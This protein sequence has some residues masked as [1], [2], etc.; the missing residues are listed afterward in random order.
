[1]FVSRSVSPSSQVCET[2]GVRDLRHASL[3]ACQLER[4]SILTWIQ[5]RAY[6]IKKCCAR[7]SWCRSALWLPK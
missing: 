2:S 6:E 7:P 4:C 3:E 1:M 5:S